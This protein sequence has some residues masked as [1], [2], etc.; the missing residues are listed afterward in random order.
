MHTNP[1]AIVTG[2]TRGI[3][4]A[5]CVQLAKDGFSIVTFGR[6]A[7]D[8]IKPNLD[9][10]RNALQ[11]DGEI[12]H[13]QGSIDSEKD[14]ERLFD[15]TVQRF[16]RIDTLINNAG[17][18]PSVRQDL[19]STTPESFDRVMSI[20]LRGPFFLTQR[21]A[22]FMTQKTCAIENYCP[23]IINIS[24]ISAYVSS[25]MRGEYCISKAGLSM[26]TCLFADRLAEFGINVYEIRPGIIATDMTSAVTEK[27]TK[28]IN[29]GLLPIKR[30]GTPQD[31]ADA[32]S[33]LCS[34]KLPYSTGEIINIDGGFHLRRL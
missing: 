9:L 3:G 19:L 10:I 17:V 8:E 20:N 25:T 1:V 11:K 23:M 30:W 28:M 24:S 33:V 21:I 6:S 29:D 16:G 7:A 13:V 31:V 2:G 5:I 26:L 4:N 12:L 15:E 34:G 14:R 32:V 27:Y 18:A 22:N